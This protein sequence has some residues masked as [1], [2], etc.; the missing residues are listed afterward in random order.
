MHYHIL[1]AVSIWYQSVKSSAF[2]N[3][4]NA[5]LKGCYFHTVV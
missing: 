2:D 5:N 1:T 4:N 3:D